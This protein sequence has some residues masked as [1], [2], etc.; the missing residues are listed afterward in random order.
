M[1]KLEVGQLDSV[2]QSRFDRQHWTETR[3]ESPSG[4]SYFVEVGGLLWRGNP[5]GFWG[6]AFIDAATVPKI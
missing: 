1:R 4:W 2:S 5:D 6:P 3:P